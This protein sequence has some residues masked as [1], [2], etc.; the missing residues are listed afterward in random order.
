MDKPVGGAAQP[1]R[2]FPPSSSTVERHLELHL[3]LHPV[4]RLLRAVVVRL[5]LQ[6]SSLPHLH[7][8]E[9][10]FEFSLQMLQL[11]WVATVKGLL[12]V[13]RSF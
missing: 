9:L 6:V 10:D 2:S 4:P 13:V 5:L 7:L 12:L 3:G 11:L 8:P 1:V